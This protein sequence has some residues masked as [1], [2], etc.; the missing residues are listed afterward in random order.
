MMLVIDKNMK[1]NKS[2]KLVTLTAALLL[3]TSFQTPIQAED[4]DMVFVKGGAVPAPKITKRNISKELEGG[5]YVR[6]Q[7]HPLYR[8]QSDQ[9]PE[10]KQRAQGFLKELE[11]EKKNRK[12]MQ[13]G[14]ST[15]K[16]GEFAGKAE[17]YLEKAAPIVGGISVLFPITAP[18]VGPLYAGTKYI[19]KGAHKVLPIVGDQ[20]ELHYATKLSQRSYVVEHMNEEERNELIIQNARYQIEKLEVQLGALIAGN[21]KSSSKMKNQDLINEKAM[22]LSSYYD[23][24][25]QY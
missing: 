16:V 13:R 15:R 18:Y 24:L 19:L 6:P 4:F 7:A 9:K 3:A 23:I 11:E 14:K 8:I 17:Q 21:K 20:V 25:N 5:N 22:K 2:A 1:K 10:G 12:S